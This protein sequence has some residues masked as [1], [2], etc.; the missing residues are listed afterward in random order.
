MALKDAPGPGGVALLG[1]FVEGTPA[2]FRAAVESSLCEWRGTVDSN[3][4][5][6]SHC[7]RQTITRFSV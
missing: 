7:A 2:S 6:L 1:H 3:M 5:F 4:H